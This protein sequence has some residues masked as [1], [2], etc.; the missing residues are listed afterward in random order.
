M[1]KFRCLDRIM[2]LE[3]K[4]TDP[5]MK[6]GAFAS[7]VES[8]EKLVSVAVLYGNDA[9]PAGCVALVR[10]SVLK[11]EALEVEEHKVFIVKMEHVEAWGPA[12][13]VARNKFNKD[14]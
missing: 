8:K 12:A 6:T 9:V 4:V 2:V 10:N 5:V 13:S 14:L 11:G 7:V 1:N 3:P